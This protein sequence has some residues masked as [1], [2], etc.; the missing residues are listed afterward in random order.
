MSKIPL[1]FPTVITIAGKSVK[2]MHNNIIEFALRAVYKHF[3]ELVTLCHRCT[4][5]RSVNILMDYLEVVSLAKFPIAIRCTSMEFKYDNG[6]HI[7]YFNTKV[8]VMQ[9]LADSDPERSQFGAL[10]QQVN[11]YKIKSEQVSEYNFQRK[12]SVPNR[13]TPFLSRFLSQL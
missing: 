5:F 7:H 4:Q 10:S 12:R 1:A 8:K 3:I 13:R 11:Y 6:V 2:L 9:Y